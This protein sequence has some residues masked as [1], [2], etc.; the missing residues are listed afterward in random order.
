ME[1]EP[2]HNAGTGFQ[3]AELLADDKPGNL[4]GLFKGIY[5]CSLK[6]FFLKVSI[7]RA[8]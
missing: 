4:E 1:P 3:Y 7:I 5:K 8:L 6:G 2:C